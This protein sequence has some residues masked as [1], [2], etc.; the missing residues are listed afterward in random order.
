MARTPL[1]LDELVEHWTLLKDEQMLVSGKRG[2]T[3][4]GFAVLLKFYTQ[5]GRF[6]QGRAKLAGAAVEFIAR[7]VQGPASE[8]NFYDWTGRTVEYHRAQ[9]PEHLGFRECSVAHAEKVTAYLAEHGAH[10]ER[11]PEQVRAELLAHCRTES[12][13]PPTAGRC[14]RI[15]GAALRAVPG[16]RPWRP[17]ATATPRTSCGTCAAATSAIHSHLTNCTASEVA[18]MTEGTMRYGTIMD[19]EANYT[20]CRGQSEIGFGATRLLNFDL[21]P[22]IKRINKVKRS[23]S[24]GPRQWRR[25]KALQCSGAGAAGFCRVHHQGET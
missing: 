7:Q 20:D 22:R 16:S 9:I 25:S 3:R 13:E 6:P 14:D 1:D 4:L 19:V 15:V 2:A 23:T 5:Y 21:L 10:K 11:R 12:I 17:A 8:L 24:I 18:A